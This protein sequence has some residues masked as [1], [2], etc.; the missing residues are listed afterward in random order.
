MADEKSEKKRPKDEEEEKGS[1]E[2]YPDR[3]VFG[4]PRGPDEINPIDVYRDY[5][6]QREG[7]G[8]PATRQAYDDALQ[9]WRK[10]PGAVIGVPRDVQPPEEAPEEPSQDEA[11]EKEP[12][13][14]QRGQSG[15]EEGPS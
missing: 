13:E 8:A 1:P 7:E 3:P 4:E 11:E 6:E 12:P 2:Q 5:V 14:D 10:L 9:E 15:K